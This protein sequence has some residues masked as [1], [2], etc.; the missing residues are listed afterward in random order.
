MIKSFKHKGLRKFANTG[1]T[2]GIQPQHRNKLQAILTF[3]EVAEHPEE[4]NFPGSD[5][6]PLKGNLAGFWS[7]KVSGNWRVIFRMEDGHAYNIDY[8]DYH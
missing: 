3:L 4:M 7:V 8:L 1:T 5:L 6:H 2:S